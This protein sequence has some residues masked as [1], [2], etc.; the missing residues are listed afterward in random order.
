MTMQMLEDARRYAE[1]TIAALQDAYAHCSGVQGLVI[2]PM[3][4]D[5]VQT[6]KAI[7]GLIL[8]IES[9]ANV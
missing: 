3:L 6:H 9:D 2:M 4:E 8:A 1:A 7:R 5:A